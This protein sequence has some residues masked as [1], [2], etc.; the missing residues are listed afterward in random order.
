MVRKRKIIVHIATS[1]DGFIARRDG[2]VDW[3]DRPTP[4]GGYG[5][6]AFYKTID[7]ILWA[8]RPTIP[9]SSFKAKGCPGRPLIQKLKTMY[10]RAACRNRRRRPA[11]SL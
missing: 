4:K 3:L 11:W 10:L 2:S 9:R 7:T 1:A 5:M 8:A 6:G